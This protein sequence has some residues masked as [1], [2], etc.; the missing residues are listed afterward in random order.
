MYY[1][2]KLRDACG[3]VNSAIALAAA[4]GIQKA[5]GSMGL[6]HELGRG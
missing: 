2:T 1:L 3:V 5:T 6:N 4:G